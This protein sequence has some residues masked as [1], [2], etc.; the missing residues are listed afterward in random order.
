MLQYN[1][2]GSY[3]GGRNVGFCRYGL[4]WWIR[5]Q[6]TTADRYTGSSML[7]RVMLIGMDGAPIAAPVAVGTLDYI[8]ILKDHAED[9]MSTPLRANE[10]EDGR[11]QFL[12]LG[13]WVL[14][15]PPSIFLGLSECL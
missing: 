10:P 12:C 1:L 3:F 9:R 2:F 15:V 7:L 14:P 8:E 5:I 13:Y 11:I 6:N 4:A